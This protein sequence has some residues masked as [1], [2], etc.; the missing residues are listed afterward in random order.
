MKESKE[1]DQFYTNPEIAKK[2]FNKLKSNYNLDLFLLI[3]PSAGNGAFS[4]LFNQEFIALDL[5]PKKSYI[6]KQNFFEFDI[7]KYSTNK[8]VFTIG[9]PPFGKNSSLAIKFLNKSAEYSSFVA[10]VLPKTF[11]KD[12]IKNKIDLSMHLVYEEDLPKN[13]FVFNEKK[14]DVPCVFQIWEKKETNRIKVKNKTTTNLFDFCK[15]E[16]ADIAIRR[17]GGL[18]GKVLEEFEEYQPSSHYFLK[19]KKDKEKIINK[20]KQC[21]PLFQELAKNTA[22]NPSLSKTELIIIIESNI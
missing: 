21:Y 6:K 17:V 16:D 18:S 8:N 14:Y 11:K 13:S 3:E 4:D 20:L 10:F 12:S 19:I 5:S 15:K 22:G 7:K 2:L 1:L 9:N